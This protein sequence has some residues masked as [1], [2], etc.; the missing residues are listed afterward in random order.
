MK[1]KVLII[2]ASV[3]VACIVLIKLSR[4]WEIHS[5]WETHRSFFGVTY[6]KYTPGRSGYY[7]EG[8]KEKGWE[9]R[10][11]GI[12]V[13]GNTDEPNFKEP[14]KINLPNRNEITKI[15]TENYQNKNINVYDDEEIIDT[16]YNI[17]KEL[18]TQ[19]M[20][21]IDYFFA[22]EESYTITFNDD[23]ETEVLIYKGYKD[24][25]GNY[26]FFEN[27]T[28]E[29]YYIRSDDYTQA[30]YEITKDDFNTIKEYANKKDE[31]TKVKL[32]EDNDY[33]IDTT[34][35]S[36]IL[37]YTQ[38]GYYIDS[39]NEPDAPYFYIICMGE[40]S[41]GGYGI[42]VKEINKKD[43]LTEIIVEETSP[44]P[45][46][47]VTQ[48]FTY[49]K[50]VVKFPKYQEKITIK[51]TNGEEFIE[52]NSTND[53]DKSKLVIGLFPFSLTTQAE[54]FISNVENTRDAASNKYMSDML[55]VVNRKETCYT[56]AELVKKSYLNV[57]DNS[58]YGAVCVNEGTGGLQYKILVYDK[59]YGYLY[60]TGLNSSANIDANPDYITES[61]SLDKNVAKHF[62]DVDPNQTIPTT[63]FTVD[64]I[65]S[66]SDGTEWSNGGL[67][68]YKSS[69]NIGDIAVTRCFDSNI[70]IIQSDDE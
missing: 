42:K 69:K 53:N 37:D 63:V 62:F 38:R 59:D 13:A 40:K 17:L 29:T 22:S 36:Q 11:L 2:S 21:L 8:G 15:E 28:I 26:E 44:D 3:I 70:S 49:P 32:E 55:T 9:L 23:N 20:S 65:K 54:I 46:S 58:Y 50:V 57:D 67:P 34:Y 35:A 33:T 12:R 51:N 39:L 30:T 47:I 18:K 60:S 14:H 27:G 43:D 6:I 64:G 25:K 24:K 4:L 48:A 41:T 7:G 56:V 16:I 10:I 68:C 19:K 61:A 52:L 45:G 5:G 1:K 66:P 31:N